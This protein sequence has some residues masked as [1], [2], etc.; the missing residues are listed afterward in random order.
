MVHQELRRWTTTWERWMTEVLV[1][2]PEDRSRYNGRG[3]EPRW[4]QVKV[5]DDRSSPVKGIHV[6]AEMGKAERACECL[7]II[8]ARLRN[9]KEDL[10][11]RQSFSCGSA[12]STTQ[13]KRWHQW[14]ALR[15]S[16]A[17]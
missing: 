16:T 15:H 7:R 13:S 4:K 14:W 1:P 10:R 3:P 5:A 6:P 9:S 17:L 2:N 8:V 12:Q 11:A